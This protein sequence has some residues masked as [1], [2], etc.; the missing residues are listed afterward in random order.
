MITTLISLY[1]AGTLAGGD[2]PQALPQAMPWSNADIT[3]SST[4]NP[5]SSSGPIKTFENIAPVIKAKSAIAIDLKSG[6]ILY[7]KNIYQA[8]PIASITKLMTSIIALEENNL[9]DVVTISTAVS[10]T[11]GSKI[12]LYPGEKIT[13]ENLLFAALIN[14]ANDAAAALAQFNGGS[15]EKFV[16]KMNKKSQELGLV[17]TVFY[18]PTG[19]D[20]SGSGTPQPA[21]QP[22][23]QTNDQTQE[24]DRQNNETSQEIADNAILYKNDNY[25]TAYD[26][27]ILA[28]YAFGK[29]FIRRAASKQDY[30]ISSTDGKITHKLKTTNDLLKSYLKVLGLKTG[31][32]DQAGECLIAIIESDQGHDIL[33]VVLNSPHRYN[34]TKVLADWAIRSYNL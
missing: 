29:S 21:A 16:E 32:T 10:K 13:V 22:P 9:Q 14:S 12:W 33:T 7:E 17:S 30:E 25:S 1:I 4:I 2:L 15:I 18:N 6:T 20:S 26:L 19:L 28:H 11:I 5:D 34:E 27:A 3:A 31:T 24:T 23:P 8:L